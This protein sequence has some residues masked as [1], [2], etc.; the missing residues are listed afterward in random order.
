V[1]VWPR[2]RPRSPS[3]KSSIGFAHVFCVPRAG[4]GCGAACASAV[5][6]AGCDLI[7]YRSMSQ[8]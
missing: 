8:Y 3:P 6:L 7:Y 1:P 5:L 2:D 4:P